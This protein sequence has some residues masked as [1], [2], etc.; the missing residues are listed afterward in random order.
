VGPVDNHWPDLIIS[1]MRRVYTVPFK[2]A[3]MII[4][5]KKTMK[6]F[7]IFYS[8]GILADRTRQKIF[9]H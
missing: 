8:A 2:T 7:N 5:V 1:L 3:I 9:N 6:N 4:V